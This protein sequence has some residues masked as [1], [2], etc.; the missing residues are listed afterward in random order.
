MAGMIIRV[1]R[2]DPVTGEETEVRPRE[3]IPARRPPRSFCP[4]AY[5]QCEC[6]RCET[7]RGVV[8]VP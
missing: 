8:R 5:P 6:D 4:V 7:Q 3:L 1:Y 2:L